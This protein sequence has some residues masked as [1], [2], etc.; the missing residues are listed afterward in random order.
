MNSSSSVAVIGLGNMGLGM[1]LRLCERGH[2]LRV[3]DL[4]PKRMA[5]AA[6]AGAHIFSSAAEAA[7]GCGLA[8][9][10][11][12]DATQTE[13]VLFGPQGIVQ[14]LTPGADVMLCPTIAPDD[15]E[16]F[17]ARLAEH[18]IGRASCRERV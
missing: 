15:V 11:V 18:E 14:S 13:A 7:S 1:A 9:I 17:A 16:R 4:L 5:M 2:R 10:V 6:Q 12:V 3:H 8:I